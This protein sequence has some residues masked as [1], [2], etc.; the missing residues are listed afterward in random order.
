MN[1]ETGRFLRMSYV[2][3]SVCGVVFFAMSVALLGIWPGRVLEDETRRMSPPHPLGLTISEQRGRD[4]YSREGCAYCHSQQV[5]YLHTDMARFGAPTLAWETRFDYPHLWGTRRI[6]PDLARETGVHPEDWQLAHLYA[7]RNLVADS[8]MPAYPSLFDGSP[9]RPRQEARDLVAYLET[10]GRARELAGPEGEAH[11]RTACNCPDDEMKQ[12]AF[13]AA[14]LNSN[15]ARTRRQGAA[16]QLPS[17][18]DL[19]HGR[20]LYARNCATCHGARGEADGPG[21]IGLHPKPASLAAHEYSAARLS[22]V[23][24]NGV[25]G[26]SMQAWRDLSAGDRA[27]LA[28]VV[29]SFYTPQTEP[30]LPVGLADLGARVYAANCSQ[31]HGENGG[32][33]G[34]AVAE[35]RMAPTDFRGTRPTIAESLRA[36]RNGVEGTQM[37]PWTGR[38]SEAELSAAA[39]YVRGFFGTTP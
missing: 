16:P 7:P 26:T 23:L 18:A 10:L 2:V 24:W 6:G 34:S 20:Q 4:V 36:L 11:A 13:D 25:A 37:A 17:S 15:P 35:L 31:C 33:D 39:Y 19:E 14:A 22:D 12:M 29:R 3:A 32:G 9:D 1:R 8:V 28:Q 5:R 38:L 30:V 21:S 27:A